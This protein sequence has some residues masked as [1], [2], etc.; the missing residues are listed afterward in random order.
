MVRIR[1]ISRQAV[2]QVKLMCSFI[3]S[4]RD[5]CPGRNQG[6]WLSQRRKWWLGRS[7][8]VQVDAWVFRNWKALFLS[9]L[10]LVGVCFQS[11]SLLCQICRFGERS[12]CCHNILD[13]KICTVECHQ[14]RIGADRSGWIGSVE[15]VV[16][17][18]Q[19]EWGLAP[20]LVAHH[21]QAWIAWSN[22]RLWKQTETCLTRMTWT[23]QT[24]N[25]KMLFKMAQQ[26]GVVS[27]VKNSQQ[28]E[29]IK[30]S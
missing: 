16:C 10:H 20:T 7:K 28:F 22:C 9:C 11:S 18:A 8:E 13:Y 17:T 4:E 26:Y 2:L 1:Q 15:E 23:S 19:T 24:R 3:E 12:W 27:G 29:Q 21:N 6:F 30:E 14:Q 25:T 5:P